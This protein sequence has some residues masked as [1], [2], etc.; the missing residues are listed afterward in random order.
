MTT[1]ISSKDSQPLLRFPFYKWRKAHNYEYPHHMF[2]DVNPMKLYDF[3]EKKFMYFRTEEQKAYLLYLWAAEILESQCEMDPANCTRPPMTSREFATTFE[4]YTR[5]QVETFNA[6][7]DWWLF[8]YG[9]PHE[10]NPNFLPEETDEIL[11][12]AHFLNSSILG[13]AEGLWGRAI[14]M[15][16][17]WD[18]ALTVECSGKSQTLTPALTYTVPVEDKYGPLDWW[19]SRE[20]NRVY[21]EARFSNEWRIYQYQFE[22]AKV[23]PCKVQERLPKGGMLAW[24]DPEVEVTQV[25]NGSQKFASGSFIAVQRAGGTYALASGPWIRRNDPWR[26]DGG[27]ATQKD[28]RFDWLIET[29]RAVPWASMLHEGKGE[30]TFGKGSRVKNSL[31]IYFYNNKRIYFPEDEQMK[32]HLWQSHNCAKVCRSRAIEEAVF[33]YDIENDDSS[34]GKGKLDAVVSVFFAPFVQDPSY[35]GRKHAKE[36]GHTNGI[37]IDGSYGSTGDHKT[38]RVTGPLTGTFKRADRGLPNLLQYLIEYDLETEGR[39]VSATRWY[40]RAKLTPNQLFITR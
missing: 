35:G 19:I 29:N 15:G 30:W 8:S 38:K 26:E 22:S 28:V 5:K 24:V 3:A 40:I 34:S 1:P 37:N 14:S 27:T 33:D 16:N 6:S 25:Q 12:R 2:N 10:E 36:L 7:V 21:D 4:R 32:L 18:G 23:G 11:V 17:A 13:N 20:G 39:G 31:Q 9:F